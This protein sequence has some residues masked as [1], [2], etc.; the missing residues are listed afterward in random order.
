MR[1]TSH[2]CELK[3]ILQNTQNRHGIKNKESLRDRHNQEQPKE[4]R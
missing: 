4:I 3:D 1:E 2:N